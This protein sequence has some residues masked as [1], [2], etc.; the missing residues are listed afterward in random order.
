MSQNSIN[1]AVRFLLELTALYAFGR[2]GWSQRTDF[3]RYL[4]MIGLPLIAASLWGIFRTPNDA[5][6][7]GAA[8]VAVQGW[9]RLL[10]EIGFFSFATY[11]FFSLGLRKP[12]WIFAII[13][14]VHYILSYDR[15]LW[16]LRS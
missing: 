16:L 3:L 13:T 14:L 8:V 10:L 7:N 12:G 6:A 1:L 4:L 9:L 11:C 5:S 15:I 2:W